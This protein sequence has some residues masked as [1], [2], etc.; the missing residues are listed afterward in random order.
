MNKIIFE[1]CV[2]SI[3]S[4]IE[5]EEAGADRIELCSDLDIGGITPSYELIKAAI[6]KLTIPINILVRPRGGDFVY[7][8]QEFDIMKRD[9]ILCRD[10]DVN[11]IVIG[12]LLPDHSID[13]ERTF[14]LAD[15][16]QPMSITFHRAFD[17]SVNPFEALAALIDLK[18]DRLLTSG[19]ETN[20]FNGME[21]IKKLN[22]Y[23]K[24]RI[25]IMPGGGVNENNI[26]E[27][28]KHTSVKEIHGSSR[29]Q[30]PGSNKKSF[31]KEKLSA[32]LKAIDRLGR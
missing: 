5:A 12:I 11:G 21:T 25:I 31:S 23:A 9:V 1:A 22:E 16:A 2:E 32:M 28:I 4:A 14:Q 24:N 6:E 17:Q 15:I 3:E 19:Q 30:L 13:K 8:K 29:I 20:A 26:V 18:V 10:N 7:S 27:I